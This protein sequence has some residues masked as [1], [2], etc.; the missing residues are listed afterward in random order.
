MRSDATRKTHI[1]AF[2]KQSN[3]QQPLTSNTSSGFQPA[4]TELTIELL[5]DAVRDL[6]FEGSS[7]S[8]DA[9]IF[10]CCSVAAVSKQFRLNKEQYAA[11][12]N[13]AVPLLHRIAGKLI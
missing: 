4:T 2:D 6:A 5:T 12:V 11:F 13:I 9:F 3:A 7:A 8:T 10:P 1:D